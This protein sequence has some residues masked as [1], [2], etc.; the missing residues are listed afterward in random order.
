MIA[1]IFGAGSKEALIPVG[2]ARKFGYT[3]STDYT[4]EMVLDDGVLV[5]ISSLGLCFE[6]KPITRIN[7]AMFWQEHPKYLLN[8]EQLADHLGRLRRR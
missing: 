4:D 3:I 1:P 2:L 8:E 7:A 5:D 6:S